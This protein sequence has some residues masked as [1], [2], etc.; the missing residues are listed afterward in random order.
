[1][2][3]D[4]NRC[5]ND[6]VNELLDEYVLCLDRRLGADWL[7]LFSD[8]GYYLVIREKEYLQDNNVLIVGEDMKRLRARIESG[9]LRDERRMAHSISGVRA[10]ADASRATATFT[11]WIEDRPAYSGVY[12]LQLLRLSGQLRIQRCEAI[13]FCDIVHTPIF[14]PI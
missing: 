12:R 6:E 4:E 11:V 2:K 14:L 1:L 5:I 8:D 10:N 3:L 7:R 9:L 13:L